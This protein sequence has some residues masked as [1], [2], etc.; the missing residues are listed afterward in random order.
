MAEP[1]LVN[2][3]LFML[4]TQT[5]HNVLT[6]VMNGNEFGPA[7]YQTWDDLEQLLRGAADNPAARAALQ[8]LDTI[9]FQHRYRP[10]TPPRLHA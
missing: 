5:L 6:E 9:R 3:V 2:E 1:G 10:R 8:L 4:I 7:A